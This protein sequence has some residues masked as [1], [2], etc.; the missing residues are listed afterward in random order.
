M[1][2]SALSAGGKDE[3]FEVSALVGAFCLPLRRASRRSSLT[4]R[5][6]FWLAAVRFGLVLVLE[7]EGATVGFISRAL[8]WCFLGM[9]WVLDSES[10]EEARRV[11]PW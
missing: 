8:F 5:P 6:S 9:E 1:F 11:R 2:N 7:V 3:K 4:L 10:G